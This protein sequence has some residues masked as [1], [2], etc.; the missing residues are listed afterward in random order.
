[1]NETYRPETALRPQRV[2]KVSILFFTL[3][4]ATFFV[5]TCFTKNLATLVRK[6]PINSGF[7]DGY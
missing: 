3:Q 7:F 2:K 1:M 5:K 6:S 4:N